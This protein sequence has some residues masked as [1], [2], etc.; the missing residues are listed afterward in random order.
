MTKPLLV[1][2]SRW[3]CTATKVSGGCSSQHRSHQRCCRHWKHGIQVFVLKCLMHDPHGN[4]FTFITLQL[5]TGHSE[6]TQR[7][8]HLQSAPTFPDLIFSFPDQRL[9][10]GADGKG[11]SVLPRHTV[12]KT[13]VHMRDSNQKQTLNCKI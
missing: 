9:Y 2:S 7:M 5:K 13:Q 12:F 1:Q 3:N 6:I 4:F 10:P 11:R 8:P